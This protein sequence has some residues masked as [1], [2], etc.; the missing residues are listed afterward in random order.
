[1]EIAFGRVLQPSLLCVTPMGFQVN[2]LTADPRGL[3]FLILQGGAVG[4]GCWEAAAPAPQCIAIVLRCWQEPQT[5]NLQGVKII[6]A[7]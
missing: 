1:M 2:I 4:W 3:T 6:K 5:V 7:G